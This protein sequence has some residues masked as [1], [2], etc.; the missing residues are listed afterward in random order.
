[1]GR[2]LDGVRVIDLSM[3][4]PGPFLT[5]IMADHGAEVTR[6]E[7]RHEGESTRHIGLERNGARSGSSIRIAGRRA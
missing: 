7:S 3:F 5:M 2:K 4:L 6:I 1:M